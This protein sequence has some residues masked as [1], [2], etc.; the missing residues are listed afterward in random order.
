MRMSCFDKLPFGEVRGKFAGIICDQVSLV[1]QILLVIVTFSAV[2]MIVTIASA[3]I[4]SDGGNSNASLS[5]DLGIVFI[6]TNYMWVHTCAALP[7]V[8]SHMLW[9][10]C[11]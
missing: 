7:T 1:R 8:L 9:I 10:D 3:A 5:G 2:M 11:F 4:P 6:A